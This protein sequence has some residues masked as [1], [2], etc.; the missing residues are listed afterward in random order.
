RASLDFHVVGV[1]W[2]FYESLARLKTGLPLDRR[3]LKFIER[4][5]KA[6]PTDHLGRVLLLRAERAYRR[7][8]KDC[9]RA[10]SEALDV[11]QKGSSRCEAGVMAECAAAAARE[12]GD[13][14][15]HERF[16]A[17]AAAI[18]S[19]WGAFAKLATLEAGQ[20][21]ASVRARLAEAEAQAAIARRGER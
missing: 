16:R 3:D 12:L 6:N 9:L 7:G 2:R 17:A 8:Q 13:G 18:W 15:A 10:Y 14:R 19:D 1:T 20:L 21:D 11:M 4:V 5:A